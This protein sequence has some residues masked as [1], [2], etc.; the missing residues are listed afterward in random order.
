MKTGSKLGAGAIVGII[1]PIIV[2]IALIAFLIF[3]LRKKNKR[4]AIDIDSSIGG[5]KESD[6]IKY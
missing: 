2:I 4:V 5:I 6:G 1:I 3:H